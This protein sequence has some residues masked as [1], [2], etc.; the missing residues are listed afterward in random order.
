VSGVV[1]ITSTL[2]YQRAQASGTG[3]LLTANGEVLT[4]NHVIKGATAITVQVIGTGKTYTATVVGTS[5]H[6]DIAVLHLSNASGLPI[7]RVGTAKGSAVGDAVT[8]VGNA[9]GRGSPT[10]SAGSIVA[11]GQTITA[12]DA[13]GSN[14]ETISNLIEINAPLLPGDSGGPLYAASGKVIGINTAASRSGFRN[15]QSASADG[16]AITIDT[17]L[18][19]AHQIDSGQASPTVQIGTPGFL[20]ISTDPTAGVDGAA[21]TSV[22]SGSPA[23]STALAPG[24]VI[25]SFDNQPIHSADALVTAIHGHKPNDKVA[26]G[27]VSSD[28]SS[29]QAN[30]SLAPGPAN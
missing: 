28:G 27:W 30:V 26:L 22:A 23:A 15:W 18:D 24:D 19:V 6:A 16:Y 20:G 11:L 5:P 1:N 7:A 13:N 14:A 9:G 3:I 17:A 4:N 21:V 29:H 8:A 2:G 10:T 25:T 12:A